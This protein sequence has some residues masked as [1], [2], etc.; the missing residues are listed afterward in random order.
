MPA[1]PK[2]TFRISQVAAMLDIPVYTLR[3]WENTFP[4]L[5][6]ERTPK[7]QRR[8][9]HTQIE[10]ARRIKDLLYNKGLKI[11][12]AIKLI[13]G[14]NQKYRPRRL[15]VCKSS[16]GAI[17]L[18]KAVKATLFDAHSIAK[19]EAVETWIREKAAYSHSKPTLPE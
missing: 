8:Y 10:L 9:T 11:D 12:A 14:T 19:I 6:P 15:P 1:P 18:L 5:N 2:P 16:I 4:M 13:N 7:G 3:F 17:K